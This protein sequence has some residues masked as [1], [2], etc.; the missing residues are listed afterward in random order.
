MVY[1]LGFCFIVKEKLHS[2]FILGGFL[3]FKV[4]FLVSKKMWGKTQHKRTCISLVAFFV[5]FGQKCYF[6][7]FICMYSYIKLNNL[8]FNFFFIIYC[9]ISLPPLIFSPFLSLLLLLLLLLLIFFFFFFFFSSLSLS[10]SQHKI[11]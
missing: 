8:S 4:C 10:L 1:L 6:N 11:T 7:E 2:S 9:F 5:K 3:L